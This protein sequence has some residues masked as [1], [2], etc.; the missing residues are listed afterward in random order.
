MLRALISQIE[1]IPYKKKNIGDLY[2]C[3]GALS[4]MTRA[5]VAEAIEKKLG[6]IFTASITTK[7]KTLIIGSDPSPAKIA[8]ANMLNIQLLSES[9][10]VALPANKQQ[11][12]LLSQNYCHSCGCR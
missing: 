8:R 10:F 4:S 11:L 12:S 2:A 1:I 9:E 5:E 6:G 7:V 3:T